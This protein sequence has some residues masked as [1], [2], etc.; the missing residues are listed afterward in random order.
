MNDCA[1]RMRRVHASIGVP[2]DEEP[3]SCLRCRCLFHRIDP[4]DHEPGF[5]NTCAQDIA[6]AVHHCVPEVLAVLDEHSAQ[7]T[8]ELLAL[9]ET[10]PRCS[11]S[12]CVKIGTKWIARQ[13]AYCDEHGDDLSLRDTPWA[14]WARKQGL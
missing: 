13:V 10:I 3:N 5:C 11:W 1:E 2:D 9:V 7:G 14:E 8:A 12:G 6:E 4:S